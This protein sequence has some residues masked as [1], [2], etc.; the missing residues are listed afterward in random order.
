MIER[1]RKDIKLEQVLETA[2]KCAR[3]EIAVQFLFIV[4]FPDE[5]E[6]QADLGLAFADRLRRMSDRFA[7]HIFHFRPYPGTALT[8]ATPSLPG[9]NCRRRWRA[10]PTSTLSAAAGRGSP[11]RCVPG[12]EAFRREAGVRSPA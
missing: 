4:G 9:T 1:I 6:A 12:V 3:H 5:T 10:G 2:E 8:A 7:V 11:M